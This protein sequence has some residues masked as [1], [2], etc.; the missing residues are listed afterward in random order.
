M[1]QAQKITEY[2]LTFSWLR[3]EGK[4]SLSPLEPWIIS[5]VRALENLSQNQGTGMQ[6]TSSIR[7]TLI[8]D[9]IFKHN[10][11]LLKYLCSFINF[12][13]ILFLAHYFVCYLFNLF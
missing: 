1:C 5:E 10:F 3:K 9:E 7:T 13:T 2:N 8:I 12:Y 6:E 11:A 4:L